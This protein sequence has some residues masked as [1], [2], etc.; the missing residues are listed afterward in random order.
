M[1]PTDS[2]FAKQIRT[3]CPYKIMGKP[4]LCVFPLSASPKFTLLWRFWTIGVFRPLR[5]ATRGSAPLDGRSLFRETTPLTLRGKNGVLARDAKAFHLAERCRVRS[6]KAAQKL[7]IEHCAS[8]FF[9]KK[10]TQ[11]FHQALCFHIFTLRP[12]KRDRR[13][14]DK[15]PRSS[16]LPQHPQR[17]Y[18]P[19]RQ[20]P[21]RAIS[22]R[23]LFS[24]PA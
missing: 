19:L 6:E 14:P 16:D 11:N 4:H 12:R 7:L 20:K 9:L 22:S 21:E 10:A 2:Q 17:A 5:R 23:K 15:S 18:L 13:F 24:H 8:V 3:H 1:Y